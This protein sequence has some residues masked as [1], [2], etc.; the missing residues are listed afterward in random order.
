MAHNHIEQANESANVTQTTDEKLVKE[1]KK[2]NRFFFLISEHNANL[3]MKLTATG[4][5]RHRF[6]T[7][8]ICIE[9]TGAFGFQLSNEQMTMHGKCLNENIYHNTLFLR[10]YSWCEMVVFNIVYGRF[11]LKAAK[12]CSNAG[13]FE[14]I[15]F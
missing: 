5:K 9:Q 7:V 15:M 2:K 11:T 1:E 3:M 4:Y 14:S 8:C 13:M 6:W 10:T 12:E